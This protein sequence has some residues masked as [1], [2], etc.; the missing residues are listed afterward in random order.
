MIRAPYLLSLSSAWD[1]AERRKKSDWDHLE[2]S[3]LPC[4]VVL[5]ADPWDLAGTWLEH[6]QMDFPQEPVWFAC[7]ELDSKTN[8]AQRA[9]Q[10]CILTFYRENHIVLF[11]SYFIGH[12]NDRV[13]S[14]FKDKG[15][16]V[17]HLVGG[18]LELH[19]KK[20]VWIGRHHCSSLWREP[21]P[22]MILRTMWEGDGL[23][24]GRRMNES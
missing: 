9:R 23:M 15:H 20:T 10:E 2:A 6:L 1:L 14:M 11:L 24:M 4:L 5:L 7:R 16:R 19:C 8:Q 18:A 22:T 3:T 21:Q 17:Q 13:P 12:G